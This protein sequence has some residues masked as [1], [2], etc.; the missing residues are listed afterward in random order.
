MM[1]PLPCCPT[2][3]YAEALWVAVFLIAFVGAALQVRRRYAEWV[4]GR[5]T[6]G[7][8]AH[9][10]PESERIVARGNLR[11]RVVRLV[12]ATVGLLVG[13]SLLLTAPADPEFVG[14]SVG[15][16]LFLILT[17]GTLLLMDQFLDDHD[18]RALDAAVADEHA[19]EWTRRG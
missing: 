15:V 7:R 12:K 19:V 16:A 9:N 13:L 11:R 14:L 17:F 3:T 6:D 18:Q 2:A 5:Q 10:L 4:W 1:A 8:G